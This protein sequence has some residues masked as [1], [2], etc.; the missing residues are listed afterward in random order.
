[1]KKKVFFKASQSSHRHALIKNVIQVS[2]YQQYKNV[3]F[4]LYFFPIRHTSSQY[5]T[6]ITIILCNCDDCDGKLKQIS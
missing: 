6:M 4:I 2:H 1:M 5:S 3:C